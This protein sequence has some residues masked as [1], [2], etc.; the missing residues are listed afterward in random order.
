ML[1]GQFQICP[2]WK[3]INVLD[4]IEKQI[5]ILFENLYYIHF[6]IPT[7]LSRAFSIEIA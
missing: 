1:H 7:E 2:T 6:E 4:E 3:K 5:Y